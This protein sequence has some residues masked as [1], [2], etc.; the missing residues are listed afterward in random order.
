MKYGQFY[1]SYGVYGTEGSPNMYLA[2]SSTSATTAF[3][4]KLKHIALNSLTQSL[5]TANIISIWDTTDLN[6]ATWTTVA[7]QSSVWTDKVL[8]PA[9]WANASKAATAWADQTEPSADWQ[10]TRT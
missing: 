3:L 10:D 4:R 8:S 1:Y 6:P 5:T 7:L 9:S 2:S